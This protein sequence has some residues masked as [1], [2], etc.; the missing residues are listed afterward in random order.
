[1]RRSLSRDDGRRVLDIYSGWLARSLARSR[2]WLD[3]DNTSILVA[4]EPGLI[5]L[6][7]TGISLRG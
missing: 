1:M 5:D 7:P 2:Y 4:Q 3:G 6:E